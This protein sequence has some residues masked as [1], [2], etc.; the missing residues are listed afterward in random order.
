M[1]EDILTLLQSMAPTFSKGQR[2][3]GQYIMENYD[4]AAFLTASKL[5]QMVGVSE[6]TVVRFAVEL[7]F[8]GYPSMQKAMQEMVLNRLTSVQRMDVAHKRIGDQDVLSLVLQSDA[9]KLRKTAETISREDFRRAVEAIKKARRIYVIGVRSAS[10]LANFL[11]YYLNYMF[12]NVHIITTSGASEM[13]EKVVKI[14]ADDVVIAFSFPRYSSSTVQCVRYCATTGAT[15]VGITDSKLS[16]LGQVCDP[17]LVAK[18]DMISLVDTLVAPLSVINALIVALAAD[19][20][21]ELEE[22]FNTFEHLWEEYHVY[23]KWE[24]G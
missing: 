11:G 2:R 5:G 8:D 13:F 6:S 24:N 22:T 12:D 1:Q 19:R 17:V 20:E 21:K 4:K 18:S 9:D 7:G 3:I 23:E 15:V 16:P 14:G 10:A